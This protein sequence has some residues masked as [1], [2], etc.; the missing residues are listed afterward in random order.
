MTGLL[1]ADDLRVIFAGQV[2]YRRYLDGADAII[3]VADRLWFVVLRGARPARVRHLEGADPV[4][5]SFELDA[6]AAAR[7]QE[8]IGR[9]SSRCVP[10]R[11][12]SSLRGCSDGSSRPGGTR[13]NAR[14]RRHLRGAPHVSLL[15]GPRVDRVAI[16]NEL[17][18]A[19][20]AE[21]L[22]GPLIQPLHPR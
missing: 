21:L 12:G 11:S 13:E 22:G 5:A 10:L 6:K 1:Q 4:R 20:L 7:S 3:A 19:R 16:T 17:E 14:C 15:E 2:L 18:Q 9:A 8:L